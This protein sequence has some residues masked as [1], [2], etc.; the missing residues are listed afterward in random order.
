MI[1]QSWV[2]LG[3]KNAAYKIGGTW[4]GNSVTSDGLFDPINAGYGNHS[5][6]VD[7][8]GKCGDTSIFSLRVDSLPLIKLQSEYSLCYR[9]RSV[10]LQPESTDGHFLWDDGSL[11]KNSKSY[12]IRDSGQHW[13]LVKSINY[14]CRDTSF[15][16]ITY[17]DC[18]GLENFSGQLENVKLFPN[19]SNGVVHITG[20]TSIQNIT[21]K[22]LSPLG[23]ELQEWKQHD[24]PSPIR[25]EVGHY[26]SGNYFFRIES[27]SGYKNFLLNL[28]N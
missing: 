24:S 17:D 26:P 3:L 23:Q 7:S 13:V 11:T 9:K 27:D 5:V 8:S 16:K 14:G 28:K 21:F 4:S 1:N 15:F 20:L 2:T 25:I 18:L 12:S 19:P 22:L 6:Q 10:I